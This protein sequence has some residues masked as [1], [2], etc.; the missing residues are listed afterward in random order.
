MLAWKN[1]LEPNFWAECIFL[2]ILLEVNSTNLRA[3][4][5]RAGM[6]YQDVQIS[7]LS[8][9]QHRAAAKAIFRRSHK[10]ILS[11]YTYGHRKIRPYPSRVLKASGEASIKT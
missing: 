11:F 9:M 8:F 10:A 1:V 4:L 6:S 3:A 5:E 7:I 2:C